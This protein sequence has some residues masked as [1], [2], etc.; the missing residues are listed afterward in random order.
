MTEQDNTQCIFCLEAMPQSDNNKVVERACQCQYSCHSGCLDT[1]RQTNPNSCAICRKRA[2]DGG[3]GATAPT[4]I[5]LLQETIRQNNL[6]RLREVGRIP[7]ICICFYIAFL[8]AAIV[9]VSIIYL[10]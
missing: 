8:I 6:E 9:G 7:N 3:S 1:W 5:R 10:S 2:G 4:E